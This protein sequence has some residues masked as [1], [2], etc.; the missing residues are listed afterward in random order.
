MA[1]GPGRPVLRRWKAPCS[2]VGI[3]AASVN[4]SAQR[5]VD[6]EV[7]DAGDAEDVADAFGGERLHHPFA[8]GVDHSIAL[9]P[10]SIA[11][12]TSVGPGCARH[13]ASTSRSSPGFSTRSARTP[14][15]LA[16]LT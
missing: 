2:A 5:V 12:S 16:R 6:R 11:T 1:I 15:A 9:K 4:A 10:R 7:V 8:A 13:A 3:A 14:R